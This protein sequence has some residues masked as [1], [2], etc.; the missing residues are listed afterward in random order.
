MTALCEAGCGRPATK[1]SGGKWCF[2]DDPSVEASTKLQARQL[3]GRRGQLTP[4]ETAR[5][6]DEL[7]PASA[8]SRT[9]F[10]VR[11]MELLAVGKIPSSKYRDFM[12]ALDGMSKDRP[13]GKPEKPPVLVEVVRPG[14]R[15]E[16]EIA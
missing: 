13:H 5:L 8:E 15:G 11:L 3:G 4:T 16:R 1:G 12:L 9:A 2:W 14:Q 7:E 6:F 10:R